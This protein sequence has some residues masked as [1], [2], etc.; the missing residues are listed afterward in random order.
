MRGVG[1]GDPH[2][3]ALVR[4]ASVTVTTI[5]A[6]YLGHEQFTATYLLHHA[7]HAAFVETANVHAVPRMLDALEQRGLK[8]EQV[9]Y[10]IITHVHLDHA[11]GAAA[12]MRACPNATLLAHPKAAPHAID[13]TKLVASAKQVYGEDAFARMYGEIEGIDE[14]RVRVMAD[15]EVLDWNGRP[16]RFLHTRG[17]ANHHFCVLDSQ[18]ES[19]FTGDAFGLVYPVLQHRGLFALPSTSPTDFDAAAARASV[20]RIVNTGAK[21]AYLTHFDGVDDL[22]GVAAQLDEQLEQYASIVDVA[23]SSAKDGPD[24]EAHCAQQVEALFDTLLAKHGLD[25]STTRAILKTDM[26]LNGQGVAF[27][28]KKRRFKAAQAAKR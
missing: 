8:P 16:L 23:D 11:G 24:L 19:I 7:E 1:R 12:L 15:E 28:V 10:V 17:H 22:R 13:P 9:D 6:H 20:E 25:D 27:A 14:A 26:D 2:H 21:R 4:S 5:D 3:A 18:T